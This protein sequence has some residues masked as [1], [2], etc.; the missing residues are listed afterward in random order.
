MLRGLAVAKR[1]LSKE[2]LA[3]YPPLVYFDPDTD[4]LIA[5]LFIVTYLSNLG[6]Q[7]DYYIN[8]NRTHGFFLEPQ[9]VAGRTIINGDFA[10]TT[11][12]ME[13]IVSS[14]SN[15][16]SMDH[17]ETEDS[18]IHQ[19]MGPNEG[20]VINNQYPFEDP[21][22]RYQS[23]AQVTWEV[24]KEIDPTLDTK[25]NRALVGLT[26]LTDV[27]D[28]EN[29]RAKKYLRELYNHPYKGYIRY[30]ID[31]TK[32]KD[33]SFGVPRL[34]RNYVDFT[35]NPKINAMLR[36]GYEQEA[37]S[38]ILG[39]GLPD[40][41]FQKI[42]QRMRKR[43]TKLARVREMER[44]VFFE[45][46]EGDF[47]ADDSKYLP[48]FLGLVANDFTKGGKSALGWVREL[49]GG[50]SR[51]SFRAGLP[52]VRYR[53]F[54]ATYIN[55]QGHES[56]FGVLDFRPTS[57]IL[58]LI[59][60]AAKEAEGGYTVEVDYH[61]VVNLGKFLPLEGRK[62]AEENLY[63]MSYNKTYIKYVGST[64]AI[65]ELVIRDNYQKYN[66]NSI[67]VVGFDRGAHPS[68]DFILPTVERGIVRCYLQKVGN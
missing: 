20:I 32:G 37:V 12:E 11:P 68:K 45:L 26:L 7:Y 9:L 46:Q 38:F 61:E 36:L 23:G 15:V 53:S 13:A 10:I 67:D 65:N 39:G 19:V 33:Y 57:K 3:T 43:F 52:G 60:L 44:V 34:D 22:N 16:V 62:I 8:P 24:L 21:L 55:A 28:I 18:L 4:G 47:A 27:R 59:D 49:N 35:L 48:T 14:G 63:K 17:H 54:L 50:I 1:L 42:Q 25:T 41:D 58:N 5:G 30:L 6:V 51:A 40:T 66:I 2:S 29:E 31:S 56:A 64:A